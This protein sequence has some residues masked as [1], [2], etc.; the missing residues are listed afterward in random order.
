MRHDPA[1]PPQSSPAEHG[2][3]SEAVRGGHS[4]SVMPD[5]GG[6]TCVVWQNAHITLFTPTP[7]P[8]WYLG[9]LPAR[10]FAPL[11]GNDNAIGLNTDG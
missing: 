8:F 7:K 9:S 4:D 10:R 3:R 5:P 6:R 11:A 2:E 1:T